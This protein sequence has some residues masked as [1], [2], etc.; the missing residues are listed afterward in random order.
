MDKP[1]NDNSVTIEVDGQTLQA[2]RGQMLIEATDQAG[3]YVPR[4]CYHKKLSIAANCRMCLVEVE[5]MAK[6]VPAC[7]TPIM[8]GMKVYTRSKM[9]HEGQKATMEFLLINHPLDCPI[10]DQGGECELQDLSMGYGDDVSR[11]SEGKRVVQDK[12]IGPLVQTELTRCIHCTRCVRFGEEIAGMRELGATGRGEDMRIGTYVEK[13]MR[14]ELSGNVID[15]CPVG[16]LTSKP[17]RYTARAWELRQFDSIAPHDGVGSNIHVHVRGNTVKRVVPRENEAVNEVWLSD[18]DRFSYQGLNSASRLTTPMIRDGDQWR[19]VSWQSALSFT[20]DALKQ[21]LETAGPERLGAL[22]SPRATLEELYLLQKLIRALG[23]G[24]IDHR[25]RQVD[26][27]GDDGNARIPW[28]GMSLAE[29]EALDTILLVGS[30]VR[31]EQPLLNHRLRKAATHQATVMVVNPVAFEFNYPLGSAIVV[32]P[33]AMPAQLA[34]IA[35]ALLD[36]TGAT[37]ALASMLEPVAPDEA[38]RDVARRLLRG[39]SGAVLLGN[40]AVAH[41]GYAELQAL[42]GVIAELAGARLGMLAEG[43]NSC[44]AWLAGAV[45]HRGVGG[46]E[47]AITG[48]DAGAM[49]R[50]GLDACVLLNVEPE[51]DCLQ[52]RAAVTALRQTDLL[53]SLSSFRN[54][55]LERN[56]RVLL[57]IA[58]FAETSGSFIN[59][60]GRRQSFNGVVSPPGEARPAWKVLRVLAQLLDL[61]DFGYDSSVEVAAEIP[62]ADASRPAVAPLTQLSPPVNEG[63]ELISQVPMYALDPLVRQAGALQ[64]TDGGADGRLHFNPGLAVELALDEGDRASIRQGSEWLELPVVI[65]DRVPAGCVLLHGGQT[66]CAGLPAAWGEIEVKK[67]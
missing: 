31:R 22:A 37:H 19:E 38:Q 46:A 52:A 56:A 59:M 13:A 8:D 58:Q 2:Q 5:K 40:L 67:V 10:C 34:G 43:A 25:L 65:D 18:R 26:F 64:A 45:P 42:A 27:S 61:P 6:P 54:D 41:P 60:E 39:E 1:I 57:P 23:S 20:A 62:D 66:V 36:E 32:P 11:Y 21:V 16:A 24:N 29:V 7:A 17:Y 15:L 4:F 35:R 30:D 33:S 50:E 49:F 53:V 47:T 55:W 51:Q 12:D 28:L 44:G 3:I 63:H 9:A 14:S 48:R